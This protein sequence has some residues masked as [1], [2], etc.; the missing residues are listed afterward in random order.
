M[1]WPIIIPLKTPVMAF[2]E[3]IN[4]L[5]LRRPKGKDL[6]AITSTNPMGMMLELIAAIADVP[7]STV[8][9]IDAEDIMTL[10]QVVAPFFS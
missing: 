8:D 3:E 5:K 9:M 2:G 4:E 7:P 10:A 1:D 6:R